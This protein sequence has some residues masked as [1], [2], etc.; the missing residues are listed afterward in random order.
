MLIFLSA[1]DK[2]IRVFSDLD[3]S[4]YVSIVVNHEPCW[5][6][7]FIY[8]IFDDEFLQNC[9][10]LLSRLDFIWMILINACI[11]T[12]VYRL[13]TFLISPS[14]HPHESLDALTTT[15]IES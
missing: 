2:S 15:H 7:S 13:I 9:I 12:F 5:G 3:G 1:F 8:N 4:L 10:C 6:T 14:L 11:N